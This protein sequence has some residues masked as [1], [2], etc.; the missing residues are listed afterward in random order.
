MVPI[1]ITRSL[2]ARAV[3]IPERPRIQSHVDMIFQAGKD[4]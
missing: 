2:R 4:Y 3:F 1:K